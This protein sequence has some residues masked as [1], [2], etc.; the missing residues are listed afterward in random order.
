MDRP[1]SQSP[2]TEPQ[3]HRSEEDGFSAGRLMGEVQAL[4]RGDD[5]HRLQ[6]LAAVRRGERPNAPIDLSGERLVDEDLSGL[7]LTGARLAGCDLS[8]ANLEDAVLFGADLSGANLFHARLARAELTGAR[9]IGANLQGADLSGAGLGRADLSEASLV[10]ANLRRATLVETKLVGADLRQ[11]DLSDATARAAD[12][13]GAGLVRANLHGTVLDCGLVRKARFDGSDLRNSHLRELRGFQQASWLGVDI[14]EIDFT[15]AY[16][17]RSFIHDQNYLEEFR[18]QSPVASVVYRIWWLTSDCGRSIL[19]W[20]FCTALL[21]VFFAWLYTTVHLDYGP[22]RTD[23][24][25]LYHSVV[26]MTSLGYGD[27]IPVSTGAKVVSMIEVVLGYVMLGGLLS[28]FSNKMA[29][30]AD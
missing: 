23:I 4:A 30:R 2:H 28:I 7:D 16:L 13:T 29:R 8:R 10:D 20:S 12:W 27:I 25:P 9:L 21:I 5:T 1:D 6:T 11:A 17:C 26:T 14:R 22:Y 15:G 3:G 18:R 24:S 19:R